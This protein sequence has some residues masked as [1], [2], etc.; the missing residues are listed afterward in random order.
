MKL[1]EKQAILANLK[2]SEKNKEAEYQKLKTTV[3]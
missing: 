3:E 1:E 2:K